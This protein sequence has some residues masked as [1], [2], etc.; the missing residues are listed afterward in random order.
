M[1]GCAVCNRNIPGFVAMESA[2]FSSYGGRIPILAASGDEDGKKR[3]KKRQRNEKTTLSQ[4][5]PTR[6]DT[7]M[8]I[9]RVE[10]LASLP[11]PCAIVADWF[12]IIHRN[13][14]V[15]ESPGRSAFFLPKT[16]R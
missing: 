1:T 15:P 6:R 12:P 8:G 14:A 16:L 13:A 10:H 5:H 4:A 9:L 11:G 2:E 7:H 3:K